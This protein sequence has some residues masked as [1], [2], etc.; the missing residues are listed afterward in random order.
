[1]THTY[2]LDPKSAA[3]FCVVGEN[4]VCA[5]YAALEVKGGES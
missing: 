1:M 5:A 3:A 2:G 4:L